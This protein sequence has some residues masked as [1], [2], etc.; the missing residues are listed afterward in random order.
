VRYQ[1]IVATYD[2]LIAE[3]WKKYYKT[4]KPKTDQELLDSFLLKIGPEYYYDLSRIF[5]ENTILPTE[6]DAIIEDVLLKQEM[7]NKQKP[8]EK[9]N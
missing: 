7:K 2:K 4:N 1:R 6:L 3:G 8:K 9:N 5:E